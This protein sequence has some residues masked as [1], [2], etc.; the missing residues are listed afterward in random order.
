MAF[1]RQ[2]IDLLSDDFRSASSL[3]RE[4]GLTR[5]DIEDDLRHA[6][7]SARAAGHDVELVPARCKSCGFVFGEDKLLKPGRCPACK[8]SRL[9]ELMIRI[10]RSAT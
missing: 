6:L 9:F 1:R 2:L 7:R 5:G 3:A 4:L 8:G 10:R